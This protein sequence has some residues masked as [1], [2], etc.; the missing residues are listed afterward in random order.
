V[1]SWCATNEVK[2]PLPERHV[3][4]NDLVSFDNLILGHRRV[5]NVPPAKFYARLF[6]VGEGLSHTIKNMPAPLAVASTSPGHPG[7]SA[8]GAP[9]AVAPAAAADAPA[10]VTDKHKTDASCRG[11]FRSKVKAMDSQDSNDAL[12]TWQILLVR[13]EN[14]FNASEDEVVLQACVS[15]MLHDAIECMITKK[16]YPDK[17]AAIQYLLQR[18]QKWKLLLELGSEGAQEIGETGARQI[19]PALTPGHRLK[20]N[21]GLPVPPVPKLPSRKRKPAFEDDP[22]DRPGRQGPGDARTQNSQ[23]DALDERALQSALSD[24]RS[25]VATSMEER[26]QLMKNG[27]ESAVS[28]VQSRHSKQWDELI[29]YA[30]QINDVAGYNRTSITA[31]QKELEEIRNQQQGETKSASASDSPAGRVLLMIVRF[32]EVQIK[33]PE[34]L[35]SMRNTVLKMVSADK[36]LREDATFN[37][38][39]AA[40]LSFAPG[41]AHVPAEPNASVH[42][43]DNKVKKKKKEK[44]ERNTSVAGTSLDA[45]PSEQA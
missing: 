45:A 6:R 25:S 23:Q 17:A 42:P 22:Q 8:P 38:D 37:T 18:N 41:P 16:I 19:A 24:L 35:G 14:S 27:M 1:L 36:D 4:C 31:M 39:L 15:K 5:R 29:D 13:T 7:A 26:L 43:N 30:N 21:P 33:D 20:R 34:T 11:Y 9:A 2:D 12:K 28:K 44:K 3:S 32:L 40:A 10:A